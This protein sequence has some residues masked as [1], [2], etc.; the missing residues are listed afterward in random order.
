LLSYIPA[1]GW[2][3]RPLD[4][5]SPL[6]VSLRY[7]RQASSLS[8]DVLIWNFAQYRIAGAIFLFYY[9][10]LLYFVVSLASLPTSH[11]ACPNVLFLLSGIRTVSALYIVYT[12]F[13]LTM[14]LI[15]Y[16]EIYGGI[17]LAIAVV[18]LIALVGFSRVRE[19]VQSFY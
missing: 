8:E 15:I 18:A 19:A 12:D 6:S 1:E 13:K 11:S 10:S 7:Q 16:S 14:I 9:G 3:H 4:S 2:W 5:D 17:A